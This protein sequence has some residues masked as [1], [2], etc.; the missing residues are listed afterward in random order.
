MSDFIFD[1]VSL[2]RRFRRGKDFLPIERVPAY[3]HDFLHPP[4]TPERA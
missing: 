2:R 3:G 1:E 4:T